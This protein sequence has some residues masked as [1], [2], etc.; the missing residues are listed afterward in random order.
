MRLNSHASLTFIALGAAFWTRGLALF[1]LQHTHCVSR[2]QSLTLLPTPHPEPPPSSQKVLQHLRVPP[3]HTAGCGLQELCGGSRLP[4]QSLGG[5][6]HAGHGQLG[7]LS[8]WTVR[9]GLERWLCVQC[10]VW[11]E[12][13]GGEEQSGG[14]QSGG[15]LQAPHMGRWSSLWSKR[16]C[17]CF[18]H[19]NPLFA[20]GMPSASSVTLDPSSKLPW[21]WLPVPRDVAESGS[22]TFVLKG[23]PWPLPPSLPSGVLLHS[24]KWPLV[25]VLAWEDLRWGAGVA[26]LPGSALSL[27]LLGSRPLGATG[28]LT[29]FLEVGD[30]Q[31]HNFEVCFG[32]RSL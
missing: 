26:L 30:F 3:G 7:I 20:P 12:E 23:I 2:G 32:W 9:A 28:W 6:F 24:L 21:C 13:Q 14:E 27:S 10:G 18:T 31:L 17:L 8:A 4:R 16:S 19:K 5:P 15:L 25:T 1:S 11:G 29:G 22:R